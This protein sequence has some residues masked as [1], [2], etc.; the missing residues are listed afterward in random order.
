MSYYIC[1]FPRS[2]THL[3]INTLTLN[4]GLKWA[5]LKGQ[6]D[7]GEYEAKKESIKEYEGIIK[8][9]AFR[10][11]LVSLPRKKVIFVTRHPYDVIL[12]LFDY[13]QNDKY[14]QWNNPCFDLRG[15]SFEEF[16]NS[17]FPS[18]F[19]RPWTGSNFENGTIGDYYNAWLLGV[20]NYHHCYLNETVF[21]DYSQLVKGNIH[22]IESFMGLDCV[23]DILT[24]DI[25]DSFSHLPNKGIDNRYKSEAGKTKILDNCE[26]SRKAKTYYDKFRKET[27][28]Y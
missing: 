11:L 22:A 4:Y 21:V 20:I 27:Y 12:S 25:R 24:P 8:I 9:H 28:C 1:T 7:W 18:S 5:D 3:A 26:S 17:N 2:G 13:L 6:D 23:D 14:Y 19:F 10:D 15:L 16:I